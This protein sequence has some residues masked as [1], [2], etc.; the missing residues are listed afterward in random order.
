MRLYA[1]NDVKTTCF[2]TLQKEMTEVCASARVNF[3]RFL[4]N[5]VHFV[6]L[7]NNGSDY[8][9]TQMRPKKKKKKKNKENKI[10]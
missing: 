10:K 2:D 4:T 9:K 6:V 3:A 1:H 8:T 7:C 5:V